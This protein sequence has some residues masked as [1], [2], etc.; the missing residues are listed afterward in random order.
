MKA[1]DKKVTD[2]HS[3]FLAGAIETASRDE[4]RHHQEQKLRPLVDWMYARCG[5]W[6]RKFDEVGAKPQDVRTLEDLARLPTVSKRSYASEMDEKPPYGEFLC[7]PEEEV[8]RLGAILYR[9]TGTTGKQR[10][11]INTHD[12]FQHFGNQGLRNLWY[13][14][15]RP[16][17]KIMM[18]LPLSLWSAGWGFYY[19]CRKA[20]ITFIAG[21]P[22]YDSRSRL[23][24]IG[25]YRPACVVLTPSYALAL[26]SSA[27]EHGVDL[28]KCGVKSLLIAGEP[29]PPSRRQKIE[30][31]WGLSIGAVEFAGI[32]E[33]GPLYMAC[34]CDARNGMHL[35]EDQAIFEIVEVGGTRPVAAGEMGEL[36]FTALDQRVMGTGFHYRTGDLVTFTEDRC[37]CGRTFRRINGIQGRV[38]DMVKI[39][40]I[41]IFPSAIEDMLRA[42]PGLSDDFM[43][44]IEREN[45]SDLVTVEVEPAADP[46]ESGAR[47]LA[48]QLEEHIR[49]VLSIRLPVRIAHKNS[50]PR[51]ELK[52]NRWQDRRPKTRS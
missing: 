27:R 3:Q 31:E 10:W 51:F 38:D 13:A 40:G 19:G 49:R 45:D 16:G 9:T 28:A 36:I 35:Y 12:G 46:D 1:M 20:N 33:G 50:L 18:T 6:K 44:I 22:P 11:F 4:L 7:Y 39:R 23:D 48:Q 24:I 37:T 2:E 26:A 17:D 41:N 29:F 34:E 15:V 47:R 14:G 52:A 42:V 8:N 21:G 43:L 25:D 32:T 30:R 5:F